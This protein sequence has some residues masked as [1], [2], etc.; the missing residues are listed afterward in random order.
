MAQ[1][2]ALSWLVLQLTG[3]GVYLGLLA[4]ALWG[5]V[6]LLGAWGGLLTD[7]FGSRRMLLCTQIV[8]AVVAGLLTVLAAT[9]TIA[10]WSVFVLAALAGSVFALD[11]PARQLYLVDLVGQRQLQSAVGLLEV[12]VNA[13]RVL[14]PGLGGALIATV[15][16]GGAFFFNFTSFAAPLIALARF[17]P[18]T[19]H[20]RA[21]DPGVARA[22]REGIT[23]V[24]RT[25]VIVAGLGVAGAAGLIFNLGTVLP[26]L[27]TRDFG[28]DAGGYGALTAMFGL[29]AIPGGFAA[30]GWTGRRRG[31]A[32]VV[33]C[34]ASAAAVFATAATPVPMAAFPLLAAV[35]FCS[36]WLIALTNA[37]V[38]LEPAPAL[39]GRVMGVWTMV[40]PG[41]F[42]ATGFVAGLVARAVGPRP[43][44]ALSSV[45]LLA[46]ALAGWRP[47]R[48]YDAPAER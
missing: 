6:L 11:A 3:S 21:P 1:A 13:S 35:G 8:G 18:T 24:R 12:I 4:V 44:F 10:L 19:T 23:Y 17:R 29:G 33:L 14:G 41:L 31:R 43:G 27:A 15:G 2:V 30:A 47:L 22:L 42:P 26:L 9:D 36:I 39:R 28:L 38:Q 5:P 25:P 7:R 48:A 16:V 34:L 20:P 45:A 32:I 37:L 40:L 46:A